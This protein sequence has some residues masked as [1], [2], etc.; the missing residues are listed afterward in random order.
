MSTEMKVE[1]RKGKKCKDK[2]NLEVVGESHVPCSKIPTSLLQK[3]EIISPG[4]F[5]KVTFVWSM[6]AS[7]VNIKERWA[8]YVVTA[9]VM[10]GS[11]GITIILHWV[12]NFCKAVNWVVEICCLP[13]FLAKQLSQLPDIFSDVHCININSHLVMLK[14]T[15]LSILQ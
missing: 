7:I 4:I 8:L 6:Q 5:R 13:W 14:E 2:T 12:A 9:L 11:K 10:L 1:L 3:Q 15:R